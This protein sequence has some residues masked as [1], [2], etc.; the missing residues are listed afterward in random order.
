[1]DFSKRSKVKLLKSPDEESFE[2]LLKHNCMFYILPPMI[3]VSL[4]E[5]ETLG[6][7]LG[8]LKKTNILF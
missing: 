6:E 1:M 4:S 2:K 5:F 8:V 7:L 3:D